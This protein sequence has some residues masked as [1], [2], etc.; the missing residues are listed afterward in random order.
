MLAK[1][2]EVRFRCVAGALQLRCKRRT[3]VNT[4]ATHAREGQTEER[5]ASEKERAKGA[6]ACA[7]E[8]QGGGKYLQV[9]CGSVE[10]VLQVYYI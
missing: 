7:R 2:L 3:R 1:V 8:V 10:G 9:C 4:F 6:L 5:R